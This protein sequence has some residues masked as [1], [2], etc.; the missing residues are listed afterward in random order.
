M[1][2]VDVAR[3][4]GVDDIMKMPAVRRRLEGSGLELPDMSSGVVGSCLQTVVYPPARV[5]DWD[6]ACEQMRGIVRANGRGWGRTTQGRQL[7]PRYN[8]AR[9]AVCAVESRDSSSEGELHVQFPEGKRK[10]PSVRYLS[11][12]VACSISIFSVISVPG[13]LLSAEDDPACA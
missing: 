6:R 2:D 9:R 11:S 4:P 10:S 5:C 7:S 8:V 13:L 12:P 1:I 3:R